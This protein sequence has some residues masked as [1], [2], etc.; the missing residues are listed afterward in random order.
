M[1]LIQEKEKFYV[2]CHTSDCGYESSDTYIF[3]SME[4]VEKFL[5]MKNDYKNHIYYEGEDIYGV[6]H[7]LGYSEIVDT[8]YSK[9][10]YTIDYT[11]DWSES[12]ETN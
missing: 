11:I 1:K 10:D 8:I 6:K 3:P 5:G 7:S 9:I 12:D 4:E 2:V